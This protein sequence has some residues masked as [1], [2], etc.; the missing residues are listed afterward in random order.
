MSAN[1]QGSVDGLCGLYSLLNFLEADPFFADEIGRRSSRKSRSYNAFW[2]IL[3]CAERNGLLTATY[4]YDG[5]CDHHLLHLFSKLTDELDLPYHCRRLAP[6]LRDF[7]EHEGRQSDG[8]LTDFARWLFSAKG[9][10]GLICMATQDH[11]TLVS[12]LRGA[13]L[14]VAD[15]SDGSRTQ[16][17]MTYLS[18]VDP[19]DG[20][21]LFSTQH[22]IA[23]Y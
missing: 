9:K 16:K 11:W 12:G 2:Y 6:A 22:P 5:Y 13:K 1:R 7:K 20:L 3:D 15:S 18:A 17:L 4:L 23:T 14:I 19:R 10:A 8:Q 21:V